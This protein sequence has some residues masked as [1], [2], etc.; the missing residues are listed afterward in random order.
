M[1]ACSAKLASY[2]VPLTSNQIQLSLLYPYALQ[3]GLMRACDEL[4]VQVLA[5]SPLALGLLTA[6]FRKPDKLPDGPR[7]ALAEKYL[8]DPKFGELLATM[9]EL[10][11]TKHGGA[12]PAQMALAWCTAKGAS[13]IP[14]ARTVSQAASNIAAAK[15]KLSADEVARLD[16]AAAAVTPVLQP[17]NNP[18]PK[19]DVFT[20]L[21]MYDS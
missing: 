17:Q 7:R 6:K 18:F 3:N 19:K 2:G 12:T 5:Y 13:V 10:G 1:R 16:A 9:A 8:D 4:G 21:T 20:G 14:G 15:I 11:A